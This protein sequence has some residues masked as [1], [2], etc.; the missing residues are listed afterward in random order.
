[1]PP[2]AARPSFSLRG[3]IKSEKSIEVLERVSKIPGQP[4]TFKNFGDGNRFR[5]RVARVRVGASNPWSS[6]HA[7][8][9]GETRSHRIIGIDPGYSE[10]GNKHSGYPSSAYFARRDRES[11]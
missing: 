1:M 4:P 10:F 5:H 2:A 7:D 11:N 3:T 6:R 9:S 8:D